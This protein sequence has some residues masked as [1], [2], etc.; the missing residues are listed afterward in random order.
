MILSTN[1]YRREKRIGRNPSTGAKTS[2]EP[3]KEAE[4]KKKKMKTLSTSE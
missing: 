2:D 4:V 3:I 1:I